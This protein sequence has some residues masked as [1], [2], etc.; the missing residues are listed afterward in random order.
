[1]RISQRGID[2]I[3]EFE[4]VKLSCYH[5]GDGVCT[6]GYGRTRALSACSGAGTYKITQAQAEAFLR[7]DM[8]RYEA[9]ITNRFRNLNQ[10]Q[11]DALVSFAY[12]CGDV[13]VKDNWDEAKRFKPDGAYITSVMIKY[14]N[15]PQFK[16]G[17][18]RRR[19]AEIALFNTPVG[20][21]PTSQTTGEEYMEFLVKSQTGHRGLANY[22]IF[23]V[24]TGQGIYRHVKN[25]QQ[26]TDLQWTARQ[27]LGRD[28]KLVTH[29]ERGLQEF[30]AS[31]NLKYV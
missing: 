24:N 31:A 2:L 27:V 13:F 5:L 7:A 4:G 8:S 15:P 30:I 25:P 29:S 26:L 23:Y 9:I 10:H 16:A 22:A 12:N 28:L 11:F 19:N 3:K 21:V 17:L 1:M 18:T 20:T 6:I 14:V